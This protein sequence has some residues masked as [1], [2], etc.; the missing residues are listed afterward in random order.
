[1]AEAIPHIAWLTDASGSVDYLNDRG[2]TYTGHPRQ[3]HYGSGWL[4]L[5]HPADAGP[6]LLAWQHATTTA[7]PYELSCRIRR[8]DGE[9]RWHICRALPLRGRDE[10]ILRWIGTADDLDDLVLPDNHARRLEQ[11]SGQLAALLEG[12]ASLP[13]PS[14]LAAKLASGVSP[15]D[16]VRLRLL[17]TGMS[18]RDLDVLRLLGAGHTNSVIADLQNRSLRG[19]EASRARLRRHL[20]LHTRA[21]LSQFAYEA[22]LDQRAP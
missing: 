22:G 7:A 1:M 9:F 19:V 6:V 12:A 4:K 16:L 20:G 2:A 5:V 17:A 15:S 8:A 10:R 13:P 11:Q 3:A 21:E 18:P 14:R